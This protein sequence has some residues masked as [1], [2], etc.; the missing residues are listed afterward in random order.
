MHPARIDVVWVGVCEGWASRRMRRCKPTRMLERAREVEREAPSPAQKWVVAAPPAGQLA[1]PRQGPS[2]PGEGQAD[3]ALLRPRPDL[4][5][6]I[7]PFVARIGREASAGRTPGAF[8]VAHGL[9]APFAG[10]CPR[11]G[12]ESPD[13]GKDLQTLGSQRLK[14]AQSASGAKWVQY[15]F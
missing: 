3:G 9:E 2:R 6:R 1:A 13:R 7:R 4:R 5:A 10:S 8:L 12:P 15:A 14:Y 11:S